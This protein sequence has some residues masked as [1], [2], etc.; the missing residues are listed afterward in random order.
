M[1]S[2]FPLCCM[3]G[4]KKT[5]KNTR[6]RTQPWVLLRSCSLFCLPCGSFSVCYLKIKVSRPA[7]DCVFVSLSG[8]MGA[9]LQGQS[10][11]VFG[12]C[13]L[14]GQSA[15]AGILCVF[16]SYLCMSS[17]WAYWLWLLQHCPFIHCS[18]MRFYF[19]ISCNRE[20]VAVRASFFLSLL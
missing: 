15:E 7:L 8:S 20:E 9:R 18:I 4:K 17:G 3:L 19:L 5:K 1:E 2:L 10:A 6:T 14:T 12:G 16:F 13:I 11:H